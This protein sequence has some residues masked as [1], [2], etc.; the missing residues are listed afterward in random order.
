[1]LGS[2]SNEDNPHFDTFACLKCG[3]TMSFA[4]PPKGPEDSKSEY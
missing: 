3:T 4:P 1:M 2:R